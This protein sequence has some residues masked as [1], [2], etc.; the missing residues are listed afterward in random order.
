MQQLPREHNIS[1]KKSKLNNREWNLK[2]HQSVCP[3]SKAKQ[4]NLKGMQSM[5]R[6][7][8]I[9]QQH[10][11]SKISLSSQ[12]PNRIQHD[13][14]LHVLHPMQLWLIIQWWD[15]PPTKSKVRGTL[16]VSMSGRGWK[17]GYGWPIW[18][19]KEP[20]CPCGIKLK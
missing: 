14:E 13:Q 4:K 11:S 16:K 1:S 9:H 18:E 20:I 15:M 7:D 10:N 6:H 12:T 2:T 8:N 5:W 19:E 17:V 3:M